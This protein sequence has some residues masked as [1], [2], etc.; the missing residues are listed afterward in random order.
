MEVVKTVETRA[1]VKTKK[2]HYNIHKNLLLATSISFFLA[3]TVFMPISLKSSSVSVTN[4]CRSI[5]WCK[6]RLVYLVKCWNKKETFKY[7]GFNVV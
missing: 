6:N 3:P 4:V 5:S 1:E 7:L 2:N